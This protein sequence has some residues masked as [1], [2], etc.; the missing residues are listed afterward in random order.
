MTSALLTQPPLHEG[1]PP[2][3]APARVARLE[4][5]LGDPADPA[6]PA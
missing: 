4:A 3:E 5:L 1:L 6:N 2:S